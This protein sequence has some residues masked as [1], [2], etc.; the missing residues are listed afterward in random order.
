LFYLSVFQT[1]FSAPIGRFKDIPFDPNQPPLADDDKNL[2][3]HVEL[4]F[5]VVSSILVAVDVL[6]SA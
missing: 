2:V 1:E 4:P 6:M 5:S 3:M